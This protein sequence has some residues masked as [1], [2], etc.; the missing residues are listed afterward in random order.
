MTIKPIENIRPIIRNREAEAKAM[1]HIRKTAVCAFCSCRA[2]CACI[3][4]NTRMCQRHY[5]QNGGAVYCPDHEP[6]LVL[7]KETGD[8]PLAWE[9]TEPQ[10]N[11]SVCGESLSECG[12]IH[13]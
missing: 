9:I 12:G 1:E 6:K 10:G 2:V 4:C 8:V 5:R 13:S 3:Q 7:A 11:C